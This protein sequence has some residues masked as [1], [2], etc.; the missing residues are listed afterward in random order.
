[1]GA[2]D[3]NALIS[4]VEEFQS[5]SLRRV[6]LIVTLVLTLAPVHNPRAQGEVPA[7]LKPLLARPVSEMRLVVTR[8]NADRQTLNAN[9][10]GPSGFNRPGGGGRG[11]AGVNSAPAGPVPISAPRLA[12]LKRFGL[13]W[14]AA[15]AAFP[16]AK[17]TA[18]AVSDLTALQASVS[19][20]LA[21]LE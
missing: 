6:P 9:Y 16:A 4:S 7:D 5:M 15:L 1:P 12:R 13:D 11:G 8:Y 10:A 17:L 14:Q 2:S 19:R 20:D 21:Q 3:G 18:A